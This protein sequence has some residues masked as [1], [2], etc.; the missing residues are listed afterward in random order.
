MLKNKNMKNNIENTKTNQGASP[1]SVWISQFDP[2]FSFFSKPITNIYPKDV[3]NLVDA[4]LL[5][6]G[7]TYKEVTDEYRWFYFYAKEGREFKKENFDYCT[8][9]GTFSSRK[10]G[11]LIKHSELL[12]IDFDHVADV[13]LLKERLIE[14]EYLETELIYVSP[15]GEGVK[16]IIKIDLSKGTHREYF[17]AVSNYIKAIYSIEIDESGKDV[18]RAC[19]LCHD[20]DVFINPKYLG[21]GNPNPTKPFDLDKWK[22]K[23]T[24]KSEQKAKMTP[25]NNDT[26]SHVEELIQQIES[27]RIDLTT[28]YTDWIRVGFALAHEFGEQG[29]EYFHRVSQ[30]HS[31]YSREECDR[32]YTNCLKSNGSGVGIGTFFQ[33]CKDE[34]ITYAIK[35]EVKEA[36]KINQAPVFPDS[37]Y[38]QLPHFLK[39]VI[40]V[41]KTPAEKDT[42]LIGAIGV[43]SA[44]LSK[45]FGIYDGK[46]VYPNLYVFI[47]GS[48]SAGKGKLNYSKHLVNAIHEALRRETKLRR[49]S[50]NE[51]MAA[52]KK[53]KDETRQKPSYPLERMLL[54]PAN[55]S[56]SGTYLL[57]ADNN[58]IGLIFETEGD[59]L[60]LAFKTD[61]GNYSDGFRKAFHHEAISYYRK[62]DRE[63]VDIKTP[64]LSAVLSGTP[65]QINALIPSAENG[66]FSR[67]LFYKIEMNPKWKDVFDKSVGGGLD[68]FF[69]TLGL[70]FHEFYNKLNEGSEI[71][72]K[73]TQG[74]EVEFN[75]FFEEI[76][77]EYLELLGEEYIATV[78]RLGLSAFR[79][80]MTISALR[81]MESR[82]FGNEL[83]CTD[84]DLQTAFDMV[85]VLIKHAE[86]VFS[87]LPL[88]RQNT[89]RKNMM[90][91]FLE[92]L[93]PEFN[94]KIYLDIASKKMIPPKTADRYIKV[95]YERGFIDKEGHDMYMKK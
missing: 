71:G 13:T 6:K 21:K 42:L 57:L 9:S 93:P 62:T 46:K 52:Y 60:T 12:T 82:D 8:Y 58:G 14:D 92:E 25:V 15:S 30:M 40:S 49:D 35:R 17:E 32:Q 66:L 80:C 34:G 85:K 47:T 70:E 64:R 61:Y 36:A 88:E 33:M 91:K 53:A 50:Y 83:I 37:V 89:P 19:F 65:K 3:L 59:T 5:I 87:E 67:F 68:N 72:F 63:Y 51:E 16:C 1:T 10:D 73:M 20:A 26:T 11:G 48:A 23:A 94:R 2:K 84:Q 41:G 54:I 7:P 27:R 79:V 44:C 38:P 24:P 55:S 43:L 28:T 81:L 22:T 69:E 76:N 39:R 75:K 45:I 56:A 78:R 95:L 18:S 31:K 86:Q 90:E 29:R 4:Y 74:Q 77:A